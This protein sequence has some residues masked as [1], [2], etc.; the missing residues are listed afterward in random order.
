MEEI[1][2]PREW[3]HTAQ[4]ILK[5]GCVVIV[6]GGVDSGKTTFVTFLVNELLTAGLSCAVVDADVGQSNV[7]PPGTI[8]LGFP[9]YPVEN[10]G[11]MLPTAFYF[12]GAISP[13]RHLLPCVVGTKKMVELALSNKMGCVVERVI[14]D[15]TG[16]VEG[17]LGRTLK[18]FKLDLLSPDHI[19]FFQLRRELES[20]ACL[21]EGR[22]QV[23]RLRVP[24]SVQRKTPHLRASKRE[25]KWRQFFRGSILREF[26]FQDVKFTRTF[27]NTGQPL[28][29]EWRENLSRSFEKGLLWLECTPEQSWVIAQEQLTDEELT[30][31]RACLGLRQT[32]VLQYH[33]SYFEEVLVALVDERGLAQAVGI[34]KAIDFNQQKIKILSSLPEGKKIREIQFSDFR[35][36]VSERSRWRTI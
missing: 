23:H 4:E 18:E 3:Y 12:V 26:S 33:P 31:L 6:I 35:F 1:R 9:E 7:G 32:R 28:N 2:Y 13:R 24:P 36:L 15:T 29:K 27:L 20:L 10:L 8:G 25:E 21:W 19:V 22:S 14:V 34:I 16:L 5:K 17:R 30:W 11:E